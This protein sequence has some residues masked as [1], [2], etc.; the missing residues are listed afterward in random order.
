MVQAAVQAAG[1]M[2][3]GIGGYEAGKYNRNADYAAATAAEQ[4]G[5]DQ[6][7]R[8]RQNA[9]A[10]I[11]QQVAGQGE[12][13]FQQGTGT[14]LEALQQSQVNATLDALTA[15]RQALSKAQALQQQGNVAYAQGKNA[16]ISGFLGA[17][18]QGAKAYGQG[19]QPSGGSGVD[20]ASSKLSFGSDG[21]GDAADDQVSYGG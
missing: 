11:G 1:S 4:N 20:W 6:E 18:G 17:V 8:I 16:M 13:G 2:I 15:R 21:Y 9:R 7:T 10:M 12:S 19:I 3:G 5:A 14:A